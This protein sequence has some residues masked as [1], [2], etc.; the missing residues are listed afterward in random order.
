MA[1]RLA[2]VLGLGLALSLGA[3]TARAQPDEMQGMHHGMSPAM[4]GMDSMPEG[5]ACR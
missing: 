3:A 5:S 2:I 4:E 1:S